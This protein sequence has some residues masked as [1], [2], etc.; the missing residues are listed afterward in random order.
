M[1]KDVGTINPNAHKIF[2]EVAHVH[3][4][5]NSLHAYLSPRDARVVIEKGWAL[6]FPVDWIAPASWVMVFAPRN[7]SEVEVV[8]EIVK[9][10]VQ[11]AV[12]KRL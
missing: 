9:A 7:G 8:E 12:G 6:R 11:F 5:E 1:N 4:S 2:Y 10:A 3:P